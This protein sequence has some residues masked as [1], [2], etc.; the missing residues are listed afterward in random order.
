MTVVSVC[1]RVVYLVPGPIGV[2]IV[3]ADSTTVGMVEGE[4]VGVLF[5]SPG[6]TGFSVKL[7]KAKTA[8]SKSRITVI[9][10]ML[11]FFGI[12]AMISCYDASFINEDADKFFSCV[13]E[14]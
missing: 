11:I 1:V 5:V 10:P 12:G 7:V 4:E 14:L 3:V 2:S 13:I 6:R 9:I 8:M